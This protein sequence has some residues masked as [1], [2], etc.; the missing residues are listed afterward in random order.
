VPATAYG[1]VRATSLLE[2]KSLVVQYNVERV[3]IHAVSQWAVDPE[4][5]QILEAVAEEPHRPPVNLAKK[6]LLS[7]TR[8]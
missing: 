1:I 7:E 8:L 5:A 2:R 6:V 3:V 4:S